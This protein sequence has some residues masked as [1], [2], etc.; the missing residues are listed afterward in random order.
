[1]AKNS[2]Q[3]GFVESIKLE[4]RALKIWWKFCPGLFFA[5]IFHSVVT[6]LS[7]YVSI[8]LSA[9][10]LDELAGNRDAQALLKWVLL[11]LST[12][13][14]LALAAGIAQRLSNYE[15]SVAENIE[16]RVYMEKLLN[17]D[18][19]D[20]D[21]QYVA[22]LYSQIRQNAMWSGGHGLYQARE[23]INPLFKGILQFAGGVALSVSLFLSPVPRASSLAALNNPL[24]AVA[25]FA[26]MLLIAVASPLCAAKT[27]KY[28]SDYAETAR[29]GNRIFGF[30]GFMAH[31][32]KRAPDLRMYC[33]QENICAEYTRDSSSFGTSSHTRSRVGPI[34]LWMALS[35]CISIMLTFVIYLFVCLKAWAGAFDVGA[36]TQYVGAIT[37]M[38]RGISEVAKAA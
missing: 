34:G 8:W 23:V 33:Q 21:R 9:R 15:K 4:I 12:G 24:F 11:L 37:N 19:A 5:E 27:S 2:N 30:F 18:F 29:M 6:A 17:L 32:R 25:I 31:D 20:M 1:M 26:L 35:Q 13:A 36:I 16:T 10:L 7:P 28:W 3:P 38:F 22:D 14:A